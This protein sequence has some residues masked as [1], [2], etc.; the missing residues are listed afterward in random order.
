MCYAAVSTMLSL[1]A[2]SLTRSNR[3]PSSNSMYM[4]KMQE[5]ESGEESV[6][7][8][9]ILWS[10]QSPGREEASQPSPTPELRLRLQRL[11]FAADGSKGSR[12]LAK[13]LR[14]EVKAPRAGGS[15]AEEL[16]LPSTSFALT[17]DSAHN[18]AMVHWSGHNSS[19]S[20]DPADLTVSRQQGKW[21]AGERSR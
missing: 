10:A 20:T 8:K 17:G 18:Q 11:A 5:E 9:K 7:R 13:G 6:W 15:A 4:A 14:E 1:S 2:L 21:G 16:R 19:V 3:R 12:P